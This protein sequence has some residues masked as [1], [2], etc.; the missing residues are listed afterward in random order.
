M[1]STLKIILIMALAVFSASESYAQTPIDIRDD[2]DVVRDGR[3]SD[4][5]QSGV[6]SYV[7]DIN[8]GNKEL[9]I[10][11]DVLSY[12]NILM[13]ID[14]P[15]KCPLPGN[16]E[17][18]NGYAVLHGE[19]LFSGVIC[20]TQTIILDSMFRVYCSILLWMYQIIYAMVILYIMFYGIVIMFDLSNEPLK[21]APMKLVK[22]LFIF[23]LA[24]NAEWGFTWIHQSFTAA[25]T[26]F[27]DILT[28][29]QPLYTE[30][31]E[32]AYRWNED[33][34]E[35][36][37][38]DERGNDW[39]PPQSDCL[40]G[41]TCVP[42]EQ[43]IPFRLPVMQWFF[44]KNN[45]Y[46]VEP[47]F[48]AV[49]DSSG[50]VKDYKYNAS[51]STLDQ[52]SKG[53]PKNWP[54][55][56]SPFATLSTLDDR[57]YPVRLQDVVGNIYDPCDEELE[58]DTCRKPFQGIMGKIDAMFNA[59]VGNDNAKGISAMIVALVLWGLGG[60]VILAMLL[61]SGLVSM[62]VAFIQILWTYA[63]SLMG[64]TFLMML[65]PVFIS[66]YMFKPTE[67]LFRAWL[68]SLISFAFQPIIILGFIYVLGNA[69]T[70][71]RL[72]QL[73]KNEVRNVE[74]SFSTNEDINQV[75]FNGPGFIEPLYEFPAPDEFDQQKLDIGADALGAARTEGLMK[76][77]DRDK[78]RENGAKIELN[79]LI[80]GLAG[81]AYE[82]FDAG[83]VAELAA[84]NPNTLRAFELFNQKL[85]DVPHP[86][87]PDKTRSV[88]GADALRYFHDVD[89]ATWL[90]PFMT[91]FERNYGF[92]DGDGYPGEP[93]SDPPSS[94][95]PKGEYPTCK[96]YCPEFLPAFDR[97]NPATMNPDPASCTG[98][99][100]HIYS[101]KQEMFTYLM[102]AILIWIILNVM[103]GA[104]MSKVPEL[105]KRLAN[106]QNMGTQTPAIGGAGESTRTIGG[107]AE[108]VQED[109]G[110]FTMH[111][112]EGVYNLGSVFSPGI[113][114]S[115]AG[116]TPSRPGA[117]F[118]G[119][120]KTTRIGQYTYDYDQYGRR[121]DG[122]KKQVVSAWDRNKGNNASE[123]KIRKEKQAAA[124]AVNETIYRLTGK[125]V[126]N[127]SIE[128][129]SYRQKMYNEALKEVQSR[130]LTVNQAKFDNN[131][132][133]KV[134][135]LY[136]Q[137]L[138]EARRNNNLSKS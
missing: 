40:T 9:T 109:A 23:F 116:D 70:L 128:E 69:T 104:F 20:V 90:S 10:D 60:G 58:P 137:K 72:T 62:F 78:F 68:A 129:D 119:L 95:K 98:F 22:T 127:N 77:V 87:F 63:T 133:A 1:K 56:I 75:T 50:L 21:Q 130:G 57:R 38:L 35:W 131:I 66:F 120:E 102:G 39:A 48:E 108:L 76:K 100:M 101:N 132:Q 34:D 92:D 115:L 8:T 14:D 19:F 27:S 81:V 103:T 51:T 138:D 59:V 85:D 110:G 94:L 117:F 112:R 79:K 7:T 43:Y 47:V 65:S 125:K 17:I 122:T 12:D 71:D 11:R 84:I 18:M 55:I 29:L 118:A 74:Y 28:K 106:W 97:A 37:L 61:M 2:L 26:N 88:T 121:L 53:H 5:D 15:S 41:F 4:S 24:V 6:C 111:Q 25:L 42:D 83:R 30:G 89:G 33:T 45:A 93:P 113:G 52:I 134:E 82:N 136:D 99:C 123:E 36:V 124:E 107:G 3:S 91:S 64:L 49:T 13:G 16:S 96:K 126:D 54:A 80:A 105:S 86:I 73:A 114:P 31:G 46:K 135:K 67:R 44:D 32:A